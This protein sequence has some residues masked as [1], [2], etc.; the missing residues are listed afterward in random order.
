[1]KSLLIDLKED[2]TL[3]YL[4]SAKMFFF[5]LMMIHCIKLVIMPDQNE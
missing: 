4:S 2:D 1:M 3:S 5:F